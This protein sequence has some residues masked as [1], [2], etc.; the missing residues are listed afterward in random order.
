MEIQGKIIQV[1]PTQT[2]VG[3]DGKPWKVQQ[4]VLETEEQYPKKVCF[5]VVGEERI[6][7]NPA[8]VG[9]K[10]RVC[11]DIESR[12]FNTKWYTTIRAW[13]VEKAA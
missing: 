8:A 6:N 5:E 9:D 13:K 3:K 7:S 12:E 1:L 2:G 4:Y 11:F 10:V